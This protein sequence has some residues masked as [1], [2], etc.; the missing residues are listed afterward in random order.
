[1]LTL[2][3]DIDMKRHTGAPLP[4]ALVPLAPGLSGARGALDRSPLE[5]GGLYGDIHNHLIS[6]KDAAL[7]L[8][9]P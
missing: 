6:T 9:T 5:G 8:P 3:H 2:I 1:M 4:H 7:S